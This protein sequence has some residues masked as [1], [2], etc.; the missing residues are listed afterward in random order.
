M[1]ILKG[2]TSQGLYYSFVRCQMRK[3]FYQNDESPRTLVLVSDVLQKWYFEV[4]MNWSHEVRT[5]SCSLSATIWCG[6]ETTWCG[7]DQVKPFSYKSEIRNNK[8]SSNVCWSQS[9][10]Q[11]SAVAV[12]FWNVWGT[13]LEYTYAMNMSVFQDALQLEAVPQMMLIHV[14]FVAVIL[15]PAVGTDRAT[16]WPRLIHLLT[17]WQPVWAVSRPRT[18]TPLSLIS[19]IRP[20]CCRSVI[21]MR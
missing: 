7:V 21:A 15:R 5:D 6:V 4:P 9:V 10:T 3:L 16:C 18:L 11:Y 12:T 13:R 20:Y 19:S 2:P 14:D 1:F 17:E 8:S